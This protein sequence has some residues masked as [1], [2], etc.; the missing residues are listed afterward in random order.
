MSMDVEDLGRRI[1]DQRRIVADLEAQLVTANERLEETRR[2]Y[3]EAKA[4]EEAWGRSRLLACGCR[5]D[6]RGGA[7]LKHC[8]EGERLK[9][10]LAKAMESGPLFF[11][12]PAAE[13]YRAHFTVV[14]P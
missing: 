11:D 13:E 6:P 3:R 2:R 5:Q 8:R 4:R 1:D 9:E 7:I 10:G 12:S 14:A